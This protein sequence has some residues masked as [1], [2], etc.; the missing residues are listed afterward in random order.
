MYVSLSSGLYIRFLYYPCSF[1]LRAA[2]LVSVGMT[3]N[4]Y[5]MTSALAG[6]AFMLRLLP[7]Y[8]FVRC[9]W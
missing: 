4:S 5:F 9:P 1:F 3:F 2:C 8:A 6:P 7:I